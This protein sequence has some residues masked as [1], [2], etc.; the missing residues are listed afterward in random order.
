[1]P[2][3]LFGMNNG[4]ANP[5]PIDLDTGMRLQHGHN[6]G[7]ITM[8]TEFSPRH[9]SWQC[10]SYAASKV[11]NA[12]ERFDG[13]EKHLAWILHAHVILHVRRLPTSATIRHSGRE[14]G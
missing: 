7:S 1:M 6:S 5:V 8:A 4:N 14:C 9:V 11:S 13:S 3:A 12:F 2:G 10:I